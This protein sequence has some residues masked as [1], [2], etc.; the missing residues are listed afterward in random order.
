MA[1]P[2]PRR[3]HASRHGTPR[4]TPP[5]ARRM[6]GGP[7]RMDIDDQSTASTPQ[8]TATLLAKSDQLT[9]ALA[10]H[11]PP[12]VGRVLQSP[13]LDTCDAQ[14][15]PLTAHAV[16]LV[17]H[18]CFVWPYSKS[19]PT[20]YI[21]PAPPSDTPAL[22]ALLPAASAREPGLVL[23]SAAGAVRFWPSI[24]SGL[25]GGDHFSNAQLALDDDEY[26]SVLNRADPH[27]FFA[28]TSTGRLFRLAVS[29]RSTLVPRLFA[30]PPPP[31]LA[32]FLPWSAPSG[33][34]PRPGNIAALAVAGA[35]LW[36]V[37]D[38]RVQRWSLHDEALLADTD[39]APE[40]AASLPE[41][42]VDLELLDISV[43]HDQVVLL[44]SYA[45]TPPTRTYA[46][47]RLDTHMAVLAATVVPAPHAMA[48]IHPRIAL[49][50]RGA[51]VAV[52][53]ADT[54]V[55]VARDADYT[56]R[57]ALADAYANRTL[58]IATDDDTDDL[59]VLC[60][61]CLMRASVDLD[62][63]Q[64]V[65]RADVVRQTMT[66][67]ILYAAPGNPL[68]FTLDP[69]VDPESL[70][71]GAERLSAAVLRSDPDLV[72]PN[73]DLTAQLAARK[74][75]LSW[76]I[77]FINDNAVLHRMSQRSRQRLAM[78]AE[79]LYA[80]HQLWLALNAALDAGATRSPIADAVHA[81]MATS[82]P[83]PSP[84]PDSH[85]DSNPPHPDVVRAFFK[86][87]T[88]D[89]GRLLPLL[90]SFGVEG[91]GPAQ[92][93]LQSALDY[94]AYNLGVYGVELPVMRPWTSR[95]SAIDAVLGLFDACARGAGEGEGKGEL[96]ALAALLFACIAE[97]LDWLG[98]A[99]AAD[100]AANERDRK[101]LEDRFAQLRPEVFETLRINNHLAAAFA[102]AESYRDFSA[103]AAL[104]HRE[105]GSSQRATSQY[106]NGHASAPAP[107]P[108]KPNPR[109]ARYV[110]RFGG[111][112]VDAL[113]RW[114]VEHGEVRVLFAEDALGSHTDTHMDTDA[115]ARMDT[116]TMDTVK[117]AQLQTY[118]DKFFADHADEYGAIS[119]LH[120]LGRGRHGAAS[121]ALLKESSGAGEVA[122]R[123][124]ML[125]VG[126]L[127][128]LAQ[129]QESGAVDEIALDAF[130]DGLDFVSV[131]EKLAEEMRAVPVRGRQGLDAQVEAIAKAKAAGLAE[132]RG[133]LML[134]K[135]LVR[136]LLQ[137]KTL[138]VEDV[139]DLLTLKDN[140]EGEGV[141]DY[142]TALNLLARAE[143]MPDVR[144]ASSFRRAWCRI[145][146]HDDWDD[147]RQTANVTDSQLNAR[148]RGTAL[149][150]TLLSILPSTTSPSPPSPSPQ[151]QSHQPQHPHPH[152]LYDLDP[153]SALPVPLMPETASRF[154]GM[155][156]DHVEELARDYRAE[157][158]AVEQMRLGDVYYRVRELVCQDLAFVGGG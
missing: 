131:Q 132:M 40:V 105:A 91:A 57:I 18:T 29:A 149:Y 145:Y 42:I 4:A 31:S 88:A 25:A 32:R 63:V 8:P 43:A 33:P 59:L 44:V 48:P 90:A 151:S 82:S 136:D 67:A 50:A 9:V 30:P 107:A 93:V 154:P 125:S 153:A 106:P 148:F 114:C 112:F 139:V 100:D 144:R 77:R 75:R 58:A 155:A 23:V 129:L 11:A 14:L 39:I 128:Q 49:L 60:A 45:D 64:R 157:S 83:S 7:S 84:N 56:D 152:P 108:V 127:A 97:R 121:A 95:P 3:T 104:C 76:L 158:T 98:S 146:N 102:L 126:K 113:G 85:H 28:A 47:I 69:D 103:L 1:S 65:D 17:H 61:T 46:L 96:P 116:D 86:F 70:M 150:H 99:V 54:V 138:Q 135:T 110:A 26:V 52:R 134:F 80:A 111:E 34:V 74:D 21:F 143:D 133:L 36:A 147:I 73:H 62:A 20:C 122:V 117:G 27:A 19:N 41:A 118:M 87:H 5:R 72:R 81:Y 130:H 101:E 89:I 156:Q 123:H 79:K 38:T 141:E 10:G 53:F 78:D 2:A 124:F 51:L 24:A 16:L 55:L 115:H 68:Q 13:D 37:C 120:H 92:T 119:W 142:A 137:G 6:V 94:R 35:H 15:D 22:A 109:L 140:A 66:Q 71:G 12:E